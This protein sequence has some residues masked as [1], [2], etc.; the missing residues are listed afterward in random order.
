LRFEICHA[1]LAFDH[2][3]SADFLFRL[4]LEIAARVF[5]RLGDDA[6]EK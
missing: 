2:F 1:S 4:R 5:F 3:G 6:A